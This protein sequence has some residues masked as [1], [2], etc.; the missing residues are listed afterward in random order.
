MNFNDFIRKKN[1]LLLPISGL[2]KL[3]VWLHNFLYRSKIL[4]SKSYPIPIIAIGN[5]SVGGTGKSPMTEYLISLLTKRY[6]VAVVSRG[7]HRKTSGLIVANTNTTAADIG[8]EPFQ[9]FKKFPEVTLIVSEQRTRA[10][11]K[12]LAEKL[13]DVIILDDALQHRKI[14]PGLK[15]LLTEEN[16][17]FAHDFYLPAGTLRDLKSNYKN[18]NIIVVTK[19][20]ENLNEPKRIE[21]VN[22]IQPIKNQSVF[23]TSIQ[24]GNAYAVFGESELNWD[25]IKNVLIVTGI[26]NPQ[27][28]YAYIRSKKI[29]YV[30]LAFG[31]HHDYT[32]PDI[33]N[34]IEEYQRMNQDGTII[35]TTEKD[36]ARLISFMKLLHSLPIYAVPIK[37]NFLF[38]KTIEFEEKVLAFIK[39]F[40]YE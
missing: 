27:P 25:K 4:A 29:D 12:I 33:L 32:K 5:L 1:K 39:N 15:I 37:H 36:A 28:L 6:K 19:C 17:L 2:Y 18:A 11:E 23:F 13:A 21:I 22:T 38:N 14:N 35:F 34:I 8:D 7:Y 30:P 9:I 3:G 16:N 10:I 31:D 24:Y 40:N 26:A 20:E